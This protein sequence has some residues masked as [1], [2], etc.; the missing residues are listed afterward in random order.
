MTKLSSCNYNY[1]FSILVSFFLGVTCVKATF[2]MISEVDF[3]WNIIWGILILITLLSCLKFC[4]VIWRTGAFFPYLVLNLFLGATY[5]FSSRSSLVDHEFLLSSSKILFAGCLPLFLMTYSITDYETLYK[6]MVLISVIVVC[7]SLPAIFYVFT[8]GGRTEYSMAMSSA[9]V[10]PLLCIFSQYLRRKNW[11]MLTLFLCGVFIIF[12]WGS[13]GSLLCIVCYLLFYAL[14]Y[15][16]FKW[17]IFV[18]TILGICVIVNF[19]FADFIIKF[20][21]YCQEEFNITSRTFMKILEYWRDTG[22]DGSFLARKELFEEWKNLVLSDPFSSAGVFRQIPI[23]SIGPDGEFYNFVN[24]AI[25]PHNIFLEITLVYGL[26]VGGI[27]SLFLIWYLVRPLKKASSYQKKLWLIF[28]SASLLLMFS[29]TV[30]NSLAFFALLGISHC[31]NQIIP[32][33][34][35][36]ENSLRS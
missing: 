17:R 32:R 15:S 20:L 14:I 6:K 4:F 2:K 18:Y 9:L 21:T 34:I 22:D 27:I 30:F 5:F 7:L 33:R 28:M 26:V 31:R 29:G 13:R 35:E 23:I 8:I 11:L 12:C 3:V 36:N 10:L 25:Y 1:I 19:L 16:T 24:F